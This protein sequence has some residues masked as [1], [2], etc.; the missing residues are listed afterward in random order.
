MTKIITCLLTMILLFM[1]SGC[2]LRPE[3]KNTYVI[4]H[5]GDPIQALD[6]KDGKAQKVI[7]TGKSSK[8][9]AVGTQDVTGWFMMDPDHWKAIKEDLD[10]KHPEAPNK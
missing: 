4:V 5:P 10:K 1:T 7:I 6:L 3:E 8:T 2:S 9:G